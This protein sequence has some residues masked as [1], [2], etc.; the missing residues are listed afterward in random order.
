M[1]NVVHY[2]MDSFK[3]QMKELGVGRVNLEKIFERSKEMIPLFKN[4]Y[5]RRNG[6][7]INNTLFFNN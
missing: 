5:S 1:I 2:D 4:L 3:K 7:Q 6:E